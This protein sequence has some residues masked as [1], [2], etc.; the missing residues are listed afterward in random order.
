MDVLDTPTLLLGTALLCALLIERL[1]EI[2]KSLYDY[3]DARRDFSDYWNRKAERIGNQLAVRYRHDATR[4]EVAFDPVLM[5]A[6][7]YFVASETVDG[8][9]R[10][11]A[12]LVRQNILQGRFK[13]LGMLLGIAIAFGLQLD[14]FQLTDFVLSGTRPGEPDVLGL[15][16]SGV[17]MGLG[18]TPMHQLLSRL[19]QAGQARRRRGV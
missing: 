13:V 1:L 7:R 5:L 9:W 17:A 16:L 3:L 10:V 19:E 11:S 4:N 6:R 12:D 14:L 15:I 2:G 18:A 8:E